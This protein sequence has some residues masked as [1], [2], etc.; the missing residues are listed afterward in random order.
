MADEE[1]GSAPPFKASA[2]RAKRKSKAAAE[3]RPDASAWH[4]DPFGRYTKRWWDGD[5]WS[6]KVKAANGQPGLDPPGIDPHP[7]GAPLAEP[8]SP[9]H[10]AHLPIKPPPV[11]GQL[12]F[13][14]GL[15]VFGALI[16]LMGLFLLGVI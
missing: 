16:V 14:L 2:R 5:R 8:A 11:S 7:V 1:T 12:T 13:A 10:D 15:V 4:A 3:E 6:E 9:I